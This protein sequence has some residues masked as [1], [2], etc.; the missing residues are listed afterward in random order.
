[1][2]QDKKIDIKKLISLTIL[3]I[4]ALEKIIAARVYQVVGLSS[5]VVPIYE[6]IDRIFRRLGDS[7][8]FEDTIR[9]YDEKFDHKEIKELIKICSSPTYKKFQQQTEIN[10][11]IFKSLFK[12]IDQELNALANK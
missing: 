12:I 1:M 10:N 5:K 3:H 8:I 6:I 2:N 7:E 9:R 4:E 11:E